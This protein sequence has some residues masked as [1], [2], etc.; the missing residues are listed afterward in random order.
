MRKFAVV[1]ALIVCA[2]VQ[3]C[4]EGE[5]PLGLSLAACNPSLYDVAYGVKGYVAV[6]GYGVAKQSIDGTLWR[7]VLTPSANSLNRVCFTGKEYVAVG[8]HGTIVASRD[9]LA[10]EL[11]DSGTTADLKGICAAAA[12][13]V[14][15]GDEGTVLSSKDDQTWTA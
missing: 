7:T 10:W 4:A 2:S 13:I 6:G 5:N 1:F 15:V 8:Y 14:I 9:G 3:L 12:K 11:R